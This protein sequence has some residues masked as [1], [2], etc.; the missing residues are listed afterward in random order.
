[1]VDSN[2]TIHT[3]N[4]ILAL[5]A[6][7]L[8]DSREMTGII[9]RSVMTTDAL[10]AVA[11]KYGLTLK[12]TPVGFKHIGEIMKETESITRRQMESF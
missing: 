2:G 10:D 12:E 8:C 11:R 1:M 7:Y 4:E 3:P 6:K 9:V 5:L